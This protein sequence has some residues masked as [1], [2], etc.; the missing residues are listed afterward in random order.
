[1]ASIYDK[2]SL[3]LIPSG[4]KTSKLYSQKPVSGDGD[5]TFSRSTA[6]T[7]VN[8]SGNIEK[9]TQ[10]LFT[11][12]NTFSDSSWYKVNTSVTGGQSG[13]DGTNDAWLLSKSAASAQ[14]YKDVGSNVS[15]YSIYAK[16]GTLGG[17][18]LVISTTSTYDSADFDLTNGVLGAVGSVIDASIEDVG[19]GWY[20]CSIVGGQV[21]ITRLR[22][23]PATSAGSIA[24]A[25]GNIYIQDAQ[26]EQGLVARD[27]IET[28]TT[29]VEGG[30]TDNV[31]RLDYQG[32]CPALLL[33]PQRSNLFPHSEAIS[34]SDWA[35][36]NMTKE[37]NS[38]TSPEGVS[39]ATKLIENSGSGKK[40]VYD[41]APVVSGNSYVVSFF[42]KS[43]GR[44]VALELASSA[45]GSTLTI[46]NLSSGSVTSSNAEDSGIEDYGNGWYRCYVKDTSTTTAN[47][48]MYFQL[49]SGGLNN[50]TGDGSSGIYIYGAQCEQGSYPTSYIPTY[51]SAVTRNADDAEADNISDLIGQ[52][53]GTFLIDAE[54]IAHNGDWIGIYPTS[55]SAYQNSFL[56]GYFSGAIRAQLY[57]GGTAYVYTQSTTN[58]KRYKIA[59]TYTS[60]SYK[61]FID[62]VKVHDVSKSTSFAVL[63]DRLSVTGNSLSGKKGNIKHKQIL[64]LPTALTDQEAIDLTTL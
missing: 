39:N 31:P 51:G 41:S 25:S 27:Y 15:T 8:A 30:I 2:A 32:S 55:G 43:N 47:A 1:M 18:R 10:N 63:L 21:P 16:A 17:I 59:I 40:Q 13:Y 19:G 3:V 36:S 26:L 35:V 23:Y 4:T 11:Y 5:F 22:M 53:E 48:A 61:V 28:T 57:A 54:V 42:A 56:L 45:F 50:Y 6:A 44:D 14:V 64:V 7:R 9:E 24:D 37:A 62:G 34:I 20:R 52:T 46:F 29:A 58:E 38:T 33:E 60:S 12:S 49:V